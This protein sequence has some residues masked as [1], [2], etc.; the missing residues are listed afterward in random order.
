VVWAIKNDNYPSGY[1]L[2]FNGS[3][4]WCDTE[5]HWNGHTFKVRDLVIVII[6]NGIVEDIMPIC[7]SLKIYGEY[8]EEV[9]LLRY[10]RDNILNKTPEGREL[11]KLYYQWSPLIV[12]AMEEDEEFKEDVKEV[13]DEV[14]GLVGG[15]I[16]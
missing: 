12:K 4:S 16:E 5:L 6:K 10:I 13:I 2:Y 1:I 11:I 7:L 3:W 14:L 15:D 9:E 8:S